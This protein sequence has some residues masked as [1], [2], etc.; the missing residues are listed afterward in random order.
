MPMT[1]QLENILEEEARKRRIPLSVK[2]ELLPV[3]NLNCKMC[4][5]RTDMNDVNQHG[6]LIPAKKWIQLAQQLRKAGTLYILLTGGEVF[7][8]PEFK[9]LYQELVR[10][11]F[12]VTI[13]TNATLIDQKTMDWLREYPP[14]LMSISLYGA[15]NDTYETLCGQKG[16]FDRADRAIRGLVESGIRVELKTMLNPINV[17]EA[18]EMY[19]YSQK[20]GVYYEA[21]SYAYP[22]A[23]KSDGS[24]AYRFSPREAARQRIEANRR[25]CNDQKFAF[26]ILGYLKKYEETKNIPGYE[27]KGFTCGAGNSSCWVNWKGH[28]TPC[29]MMEE[30][31]TYP[32]AE[33]FDTA[34]ENLKEQCDQIVMSLQCST[35]D[36][37]GICSVC[38]AANLVETGSFQEASPFHCEMTECLLNDMR[39]IVTEWGIDPGILRCGKEG[40]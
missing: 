31:H 5:I 28:L 30:P 32:F 16:M 36:K 15:S 18:Q 39:E 8:Y 29:V 4:Y 9:F 12:A 3:C 40:V 2:M 21:A 24:Q 14:R 13:N 22:P 34:W 25:T 1:N 33:G 7:L 38:P 6:G 20:L 26:D 10:M 27:Q 19:A 37:R 35:C 11:G 23:R 17:H